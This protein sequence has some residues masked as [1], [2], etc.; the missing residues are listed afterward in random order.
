MNLYAFFGKLVNG[1][2]TLVPY[3]N[4]SGYFLFPWRQG[5]IL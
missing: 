4:L 5:K 1:F 2:P 3:G